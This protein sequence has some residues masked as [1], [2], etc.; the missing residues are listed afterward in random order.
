M[1]AKEIFNSQR[2]K[3][4][5][6]GNKTMNYAQNSQQQEIVKQKNQ[7]ERKNFGLL[8]AIILHAKEEKPQMQDRAS[9]YSDRLRVS[10]YI[11]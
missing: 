4:S 9:Y 11:F 1:G 6:I 2:L 7:R 8:F 3:T 10:H 5:I